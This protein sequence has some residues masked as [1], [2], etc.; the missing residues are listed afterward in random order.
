MT[1]EQFTS[2]MKKI[3]IVFWVI[4]IAIFAY[5]FI[6]TSGSGGGC[7]ICGAKATHGSYCAEH[8]EKA[9]IWAMENT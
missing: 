5:L 2:V 7:A 9:I 4:A 1:N 6:S 8:Y 3:A